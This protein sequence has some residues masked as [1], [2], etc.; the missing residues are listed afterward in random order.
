MLDHVIM[1]SHCIFK[2]ANMLSMD[3]FHQHK[4]DHCYFVNRLQKCT[5]GCPFYE[6]SF[7]NDV[8]NEYSLS[9]IDTDN[10]FHPL[11]CNIQQFHEAISWLILGV[12]PANGRRHYNVT[13][14]LIGQ[15]QA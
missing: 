14:S 13:P 3:S 5:A 10:E 11:Q 2:Q 4:M 9:I 6:W 15:A 12:R 1:R 7:A 8:C